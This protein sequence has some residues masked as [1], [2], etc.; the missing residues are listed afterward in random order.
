MLGPDP[1]A[2]LYQK[3][4]GQI[5]DLWSK[6]LEGGRMYAV[7]LGE[8]FT[9]PD[10]LITRYVHFLIECH[11]NPGKIPGPGEEFDHLRDAKVSNYTFEVDGAQAAAT[12]D[13][14]EGLQR[15]IH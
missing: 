3:A 12:T 7:K 8:L 14:F 2:A 10:V 9:L 4:F 5:E 1:D 15:S 6:L 13:V 11:L